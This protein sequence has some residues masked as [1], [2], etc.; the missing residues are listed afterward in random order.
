MRTLMVSSAAIAAV[1]IAATPSALTQAQQDQASQSRFCLQF[2]TEGQARC[3]YRTLAQCEHARARDSAGRCF[4]R[5]YM[6]A[7]TPPA[8]AAPAPRRPTKHATPSW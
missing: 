2:G 4:D 1:L 6:I 5:T 7:A 8:D 3:G